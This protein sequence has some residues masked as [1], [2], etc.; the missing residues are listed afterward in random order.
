MRDGMCNDACEVFTES[1]LQ[2]PQPL[3]D[4]G[5]NLSNHWR[6]MVSRAMGKNNALRSSS[7]P[8]SSIDCE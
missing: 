7:L 2:A 1:S 3:I 8:A 6:G 5:F 4:P